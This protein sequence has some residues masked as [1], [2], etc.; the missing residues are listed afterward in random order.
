M[1]VLE[2]W[3]DAAIDNGIA[4]DDRARDVDAAKAA[5]ASIRAAADKSLLSL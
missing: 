1:E 5:L 3:K 4:A 2:Q